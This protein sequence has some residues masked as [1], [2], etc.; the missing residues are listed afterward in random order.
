MKIPLETFAEEV[1]KKGKS[2]LQLFLK[3]G[4]ILATKTNVHSFLNFRFGQIVLY[5]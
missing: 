3:R 4:T 1:R 5:H 2:D